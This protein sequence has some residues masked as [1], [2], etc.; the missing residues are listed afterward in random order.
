MKIKKIKWKAE[1]Y[2]WSETDTKF[3]FRIMMTGSI[4]L[5]D[6]DGGMFLRDLDL[7]TAKQRGQDR[8]EEYIRSCVTL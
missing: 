5:L 7:A 2:G 4:S 8:H 3:H 1:N 6:R